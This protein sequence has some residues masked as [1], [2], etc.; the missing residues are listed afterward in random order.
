MS[1][2]LASPFSLIKCAARALGGSARST[3][4]ACAAHAIAAIDRPKRNFARIRPN[5]EIR[6]RRKLK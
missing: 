6:D 5:A 4:R 2:P 3:P 1:D